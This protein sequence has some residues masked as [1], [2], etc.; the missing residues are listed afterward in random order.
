[1]TGEYGR[2]WSVFRN[3]RGKYGVEVAQWHSIPE[4]GTIEFDFPLWV[5]CCLTI[6]IIQFYFSCFKIP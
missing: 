3:L 1:M 4:L 5:L 6:A 2:V